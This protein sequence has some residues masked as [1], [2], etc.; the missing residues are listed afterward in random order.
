MNVGPEKEAWNQ[1]V[2]NLQERVMSQAEKGEVSSVANELARAATEVADVARA[3]L[4][5]GDEE[6]DLGLSAEA[7]KEGETSRVSSSIR[8]KWFGK[9]ENENSKHNQ[10][11]VGLTILSVTAS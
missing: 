5:S 2:Q 4:S 9:I 8:R 10:S 11:S 6:S 3:S 7:H 1:E